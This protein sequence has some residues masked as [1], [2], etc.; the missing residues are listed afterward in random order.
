MGN[1]RVITYVVIA[2]IVGASLAVAVALAG[3]G[4]ATSSSSQA[5]AAVSTATDIYGDSEGATTTADDPAKE[6]PL[7]DK[8]TSKD[9]FVPLGTTNTTSTSST[10]STSTT[11]LTAKITVD[12]TSYS[13]VAGDKVPGGEPAF[14]VGS[15]TSSDVTFDV[16]DGTLKNGD[17]SVTVNV[18]E[19]VKVTIKGGDSY[20]IKVVSVGSSSGTESTDGHSISVSSVSTENGTAM[21]T[22]EV[23]GK[24]YADKSEGDVFDTAW[25]EIKVISIDVNGKTVTIMH[26]DQTFTLSVGQVVVK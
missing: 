16:I 25:G 11:S 23:D 8:F 6:E 7:L 18:G 12:G 17:S 4:S 13:V 10:T 24:T 22:F 1:R 14:E 5:S 2:L 19:S 21:A 3:G 15:V 26:G 9:P 20:T